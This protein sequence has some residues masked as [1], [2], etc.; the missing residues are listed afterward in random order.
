VE[1]MAVRV[2]DLESDEVQSLGPLPSQ[3]SAYLAFESER[4]LRWSGPAWE[5]VSGGERVFDL[6]DGSVEI[7]TKSSRDWY[8][9]IS[10]SGKFMLFQERLPESEGWELFWKETRGNEKRQITSHGNATDVMDYAI[11]PSDRWMATGDNLGVLRVGPVS[12]EEPHLLIGHEGAIRRVEISPDGLTIASAGDDGTIRVWPTPDLS[13]PPLHT[14]PHDELIA[15]LHTLTNLRIV[16][17]PESS[18]GWKIDYAPFPGWAEV[19]TWP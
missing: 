13:K 2:W 7:V 1:E 16:E 17:D 10:P 5:G 8:R 11:D 3:Y 12:G 15:K 9:E 14:L 18:T 6:Q 4:H 19:P